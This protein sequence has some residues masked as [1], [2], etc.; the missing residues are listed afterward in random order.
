MMDNDQNCH[1]YDTS[2]YM[3]PKK[4]IAETPTPRLGG[5]GNVRSGEV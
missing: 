5:S 3:W 4:V 2:Q 1:T